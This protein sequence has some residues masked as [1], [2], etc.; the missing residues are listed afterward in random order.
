[1]PAGLIALLVFVVVAL[2]A[3]GMGSILDQRNARARLIRNGWP[4]SARLPNSLPKKNSPCCGMSS[5]AGFP[6]STT[7]CGGP[8]GSPPYRRCWRRGNGQRAGNFLGIS[9]LTGVVAT[10]LAYGLSKR[11]E[12]AWVALLV[13]FVLPYSYASIG[14]TNASRNSR[15]SS[16]K[17]STRLHGP[18]APDTLSQ[19]HSK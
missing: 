16:R 18:F 2:L 8:H 10:F 3:F 4:T 5:S 13:G 17:Q 12:V 14:A 15:N 19:P 1:M 6:P 9:V 11:V 7:Y